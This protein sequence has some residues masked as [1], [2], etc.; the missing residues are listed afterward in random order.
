VLFRD[1]GKPDPAEM[2]RQLRA[3]ALE[4]PA[5]D[6]KLAPLPDRPNVWGVVMETGF[7]GGVATLAAFGEGTTSMYFSNGGGVIGAGVH[8]SVKAA[9]DGLLA[10]AEKHLAQ[11]GAVTETPPP[12]TGRVTFYV[13]TFTG[14]RG[15]D[16]SQDDL[17]YGRHPLSPVFAAGHVVIT[18]V[19]E[20]TERQQ[21]KSGSESS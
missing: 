16:A 14:L 7:A 2:S 5:A 19:R 1:K 18:A 12:E 3:K 4:V 17:A 13:R 11:F 9:S 10:A 6:L 15:A 20:A 8:A 21:R